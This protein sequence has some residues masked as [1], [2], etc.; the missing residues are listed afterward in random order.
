[1][2]SEFIGLLQGVKGLFCFD[3]Q[4]FFS[5]QVLCLFS[6][7]L[8][9]FVDFPIGCCFLFVVF[10]HLKDDFFVLLCIVRR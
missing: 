6:C 4:V 7:I 5:L 10:L 8:L 3:L 2:L 9:P 1:M